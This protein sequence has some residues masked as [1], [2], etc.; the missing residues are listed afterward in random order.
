MKVHYIPTNFPKQMK[1]MNET[2]VQ[3]TQCLSYLIIQ[4]PRIYFKKKKTPIL[5]IEPTYC[6]QKPSLFPSL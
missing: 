4:W 3:F 5:T 2:N 6:K 1:Y